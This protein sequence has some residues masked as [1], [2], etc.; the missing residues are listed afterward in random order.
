[1]SYLRLVGE[2]I[3]DELLFPEKNVY[4]VGDFRKNISSILNWV[5]YGG[6]RFVITRHDEPVAAVVSME[7]LQVLQY[8]QD[9]H[10]YDRIRDLAQDADQVIDE[11]VVEHEA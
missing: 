4:S 5:G 10:D 1:M 6:D 11:Q 2:L 3:R 8:I 7:D 9:R